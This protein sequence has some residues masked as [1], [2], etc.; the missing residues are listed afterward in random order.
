MEDAESKIAA[1]RGELCSTA[2]AVGTGLRGEY[3]S[4]TLR[5]G[6]LL[7]SRVDYAVDFDNKFDWPTPFLN[8]LPKSVQWSGWVKPLF[9]GS[10]LFH[11]EKTAASLYVAN[12]SLQLEGSKVAEG[13]ITLS[14]GRFYPL[15]LQ[16]NNLDQIQDKV[17]L[18]WTSPHGARYIIPRA[19]LFLPTERVIQI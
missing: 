13:K 8:R 7:L 12:Q 14:A 6:K 2:N 5:R 4:S 17:C 9:T 15:V 3:F 19:L 11:V 10:Y 16:L 18:E 1:R